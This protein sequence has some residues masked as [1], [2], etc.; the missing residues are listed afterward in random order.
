M[1]YH[2]INIPPI[3]R[4]IQLASEV[5]LTHFVVEFDVLSIVN[6]IADKLFLLSDV[7]VV[8]LDIL[9][10]LEVHME[11]RVIFGYYQVNMV[12]NELVKLTFS[13]SRRRIWLERLSS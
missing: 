9:Q 13:F 3:H 1:G 12:T 6:L 4:G 11:S 2:Y 10:S 5:G 8:S 7:G